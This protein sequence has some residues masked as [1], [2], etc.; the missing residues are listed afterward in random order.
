[1]ECLANTPF[2]S[3][4]P[5]DRLCP[6]DTTLEQLS[7]YPITAPASLRS[8]VTLTVEQAWSL[9][10]AELS[11]EHVR[12][13]TSQKFGL[14]WLALPIAIFVNLYPKAEITYYR[15]DLT[16]MALKAFDEIAAAGREGAALIRDADYS[17]M[18]A[19]YDFSTELVDDARSIIGKI[20]A[21]PF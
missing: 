7:G 16:M 14:Q 4:I 19:E 2:W 5:A 18:A 11:C 12:M 8:N 13:L 9:A 21:Q 10:I 17:W 6:Q 20:G 1:M 15:G 3:W